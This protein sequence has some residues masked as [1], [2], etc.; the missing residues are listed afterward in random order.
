[1]LWLAVLRLKSY[2]MAWNHCTAL[3]TDKKQEKSVVHPLPRRSA[4]CFLNPLFFGPHRLHFYS[5]PG[6][7]FWVV[8]GFILVFL[9]EYWFD[10]RGI[11][12]P[13][14]SLSHN[15]T[16]HPFLLLLP[17]LFFHRVWIW[18]GLGLVAPGLSP[19]LP[20]SSAS[21][22]LLCSLKAERPAAERGWM[23]PALFR[24]TAGPWRRPPRK[25]NQ[26]G[27]QREVTWTTSSNFHDGDQ[28]GAP[29]A[30]HDRLPSSYVPVHLQ[31]HAEPLPLWPTGQQP[32]LRPVWGRPSQRDG[33]T[34]WVIKI[35][36]YSFPQVAQ[37]G[38]E[39]CDSLL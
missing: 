35:I 20:S 32:P 22:S 36:Y 29:T 23:A 21:L 18:A 16:S 37:T 7:C 25:R 10:F 1:M 24:L 34:V 9:C 15:Q 14:C 5:S 30:S 6:V 12:K 27:S 33:C 28:Q 19:T 13:Q 31:L 2:G 26:Q 17:P 8:S 4:N 11:V 39:I 38:L 3:K